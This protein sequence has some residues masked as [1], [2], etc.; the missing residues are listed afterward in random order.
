MAEMEAIFP[1]PKACTGPARST[2]TMK[3][4]KT[5]EVFERAMLRIRHLVSM[6]ICMYVWDDEARFL[7]GSQHLRILK[8][9]EEALLKLFG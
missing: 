2:S 5:I 3:V 6:Y 7:C 9:E 4:R 1:A 8:T